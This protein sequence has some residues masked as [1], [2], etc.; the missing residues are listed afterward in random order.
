MQL[1]I[2]FSILFLTTPLGHAGEP[3]Y[4]A[5]IELSIK[6]AAEVCAAIARSQAILYPEFHQSYR[7]WPETRSLSHPDENQTAEE[8]CEALTQAAA[9]IESAERRTADN[10]PNN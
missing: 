5:E 10:S 9:I 3:D 7:S 4:L 1:S 2:L 6:Q 8:I